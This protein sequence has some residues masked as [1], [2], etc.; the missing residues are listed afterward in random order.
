LRR[1]EKELAVLPFGKR[2]IGEGCCCLEPQS[3]GVDGRAGIQV[4]DELLHQPNMLAMLHVL[5]LTE[6]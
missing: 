6:T 1:A 5:S 4:R 3:S 2:G